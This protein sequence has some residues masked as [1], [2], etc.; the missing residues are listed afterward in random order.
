[1]HDNC[2]ETD[3]SVRNIR[4]LRNRCFNAVL[5][6]MSP[7]PVFGGPVYFIRNVVYNAWWG[8]VKIHGEPS[9]I[10]YLNNTYVG[11]FKQLTPASNLHLRNNLM[12]GQGTQPRVFSLDTF[13][14]YS[15][16]DYNGFRP[17]PG[18]EGSVRVELAAV[19]GSAQLLSGAQGHR[20]DRGAGVAARQQRDAGGRPGQAADPGAGRA[21]GAA[22]ICHAEGIFTATGQDRHSVLIDYDAFVNAATPDYSDPTHVVPPET[23]D[24]QLKARSKAIDAGMVLPNVTDGYDGKAPDLGA[25]EYG[26]PMPHYGPRP[27]RPRKQRIRQQDGGDLCGHVQHQVVSPVE[28]ER[29]PS[30]RLRRLVE[31]RK[32]GTFPP[33]GQHIRDFVRRHRRPGANHRLLECRQW[34][35]RALAVDPGAIRHVHVEYFRRNRRHLPALSHLA[36][37]FQLHCALFLRQGVMQALAGVRY[38]GIQVDQVRNP[39]RNAIGHAADHAAGVGVPAKHDIVQFLPADQVEHVLDVRLEIHLRDP[40]DARARRRR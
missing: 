16:T 1:M 8:P 11:E 23:V 25:Y 28:R 26:Q 38:E 15:S 10:Y 12:L 35:H 2:F 14:N 9:G 30:P 40:A 22:L 33:S 39:F 3:G 37:Q 13:T 18:V 32:R 19:R 27:L 7:Q 17:N 21:A 31:L 5:G 24:L 34:L 29:A 20:H 36:A 4:V 6:A